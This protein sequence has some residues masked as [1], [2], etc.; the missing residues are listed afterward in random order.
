M[1][2]GLFS[3]KTEQFLRGLYETFMPLSELLSGID[4]REFSWIGTGKGTF[5]DSQDDLRRWWKKQHMDLE[6]SER[7]MKDLQLTEQPLSEA[8]TVVLARW[9]LTEK[10]EAV[11]QYRATFVYF[12]CGS[13]TALEHIHLSRPWTLLW[14]HETFPITACRINYE[15]IVSLLR[16][17]NIRGIPRVP[18]RQRR[19]LYYL[20]TGMTY[21]EIG[22]IMEI[23]PRTVR[24]YVSELIRRFRVENRAQLLEAGLALAEKENEIERSKK[25]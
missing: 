10:G 21:R 11:S 18:A 20:R 14:G 16:A 25:S 7:S 4:F 24:Y 23:S 9:K 5:F 15:Y 6:R 12:H 2:K 17:E 22:E 19:V 8:V 13:R 3:Q 1:V